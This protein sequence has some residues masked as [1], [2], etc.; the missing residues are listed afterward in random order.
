MCAAASA[1]LFGCSSSSTSGPPPTPAPQ[2]IYV[3]SFNNP[4]VLAKIMLPLS[5]T[6]TVT[7]LTPT[8]LNQSISLRFDHAGNLWSCNDFTTASATGYAAPIT[9]ASTPFSTINIPTAANPEAVAVDAAGNLW[10]ADGGANKVY[11]FTPPF[12][13]SIT[14]TPAVTI[15]SVTAPT[16]LAFDAAGNLYVSNETAGTIDIFNPPFTT[17]QSPT[18]TPITGMGEPKGLAFDA[19]GNLYIAD[20]M[21]FVYR[22]NAPTAGG[23]AVSIKDTATTMNSPEDVAVD[24]AGN[25][26]VTDLNTP[27][28]YMFP[29][30]TAAFSATMAPSVTLP[31]GFAA[32]IHGG[33][34][35]IGAP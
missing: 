9:N 22:M 4:G 30:A 13:G 12:A 14:P 27:N 18:A 34:V 16:G 8:G 5:I 19:T 11:E 26:Y 1:A 17:G 3:S 25:L 28:L 32:G 35:A 33:G 20:F 6:S 31:L 23:G 15:S 10:L 29:T 2:A 7:H 24:S 21:G